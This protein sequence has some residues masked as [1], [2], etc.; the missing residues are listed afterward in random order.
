MWKYEGSLHYHQLQGIPRELLDNGSSV[1]V[2]PMATLLRLPVDP[3][4][5]RKTHLVVRAFDGKNKEVIGN[6][7]LPIQIGPC[8]LILI[9]KSWI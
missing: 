6:I 2:I 1:N 7:E 4:H 9:S 8:T 3:S 5:M